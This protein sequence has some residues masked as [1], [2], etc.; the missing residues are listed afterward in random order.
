MTD[1]VYINT[2]TG[3]SLNTVFIRPFQKC[4]CKNVNHKSSKLEYSLEPVQSKS[5]HK[6]CMQHVGNIFKPF[7]GHLMEEKKATFFLKDNEC[8]S[9]HC[10]VLHMAS[11]VCA[12]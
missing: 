11:M 1:I 9:T 4:H 5:H 6:Q 10:K 7:F 12:A 8:I 2:S 3:S